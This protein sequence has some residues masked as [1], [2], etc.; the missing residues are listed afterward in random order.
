MWST[1][2]LHDK[3]AFIFLEIIKPIMI[4][5]IVFRLSWGQWDA[6]RGSVCSTTNYIAVI[7]RLNIPIPP[8]TFEV[9]TSLINE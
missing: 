6:V 4:A 3:T 9:W 8:S 7:W 1:P 5:W 2:V